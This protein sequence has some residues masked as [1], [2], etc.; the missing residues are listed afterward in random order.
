MFYLQKNQHGINR[1]SHT[2]YR[3]QHQRHRWLHLRVRHRGVRLHPRG[4]LDAPDTQLL[5]R[6]PR[7]PHR[8]RPRH[9][10]HRLL[11]KNENDD[12]RVSLQ[13]GHGGLDVSPSL[14][15]YQSKCYVQGYSGVC[16]E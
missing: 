11:Q 3:C 8:Q 10:L 5:G 15:S 9:L 4:G 6:P 2:G 16:E 1:N 12:E 7:R 13:L 14:H